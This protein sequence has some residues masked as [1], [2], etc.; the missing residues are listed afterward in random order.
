[1][2]LLLLGGDGSSCSLQN[3]GVKEPVGGSKAGL[4]LIFNLLSV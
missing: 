2:W 3:C 4:K 1:M